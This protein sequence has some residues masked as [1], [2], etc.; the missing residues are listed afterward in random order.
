VALTE[1]RRDDRTPAAASTVS[2]QAI[3]SCRSLP[4]TSDHPQ[5]RGLQQRPGLRRYPGRNRPR[6]A[7][8]LARG[9]DLP[10]RPRSI[11]GQSHPAS[12]P[13]AGRH[14]ALTAGRGRVEVGVGAGLGP[15]REPSASGA[16]CAP[17]TPSAAATIRTP[18]ISTG[19]R[20]A[21]SSAAPSNATADTVHHG[22]GF[23]I[24]WRRA[25]PRGSP[26]RFQICRGSPAWARPA[27]TN[28]L[29]SQIDRSATDRD[30]DRR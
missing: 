13:V 20:V 5:H 2:T 4:T 19:V 12:S 21:M 17:S 30:A 15:P 26:T 25:L 27:L 29:P 9:T 23:A 7:E 16:H 10:Q 1:H 8:S 22:V 24:R 28:H 11:T 3:R 18:A 14:R 6:Q